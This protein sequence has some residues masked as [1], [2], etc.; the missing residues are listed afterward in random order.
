[1]SVWSERQNC[2]QCDICFMHDSSA[3]ENMAE[4]KKRMRLRGWTIGR[5]ETLC[6]VCAEK[7]KMEG[8]RDAVD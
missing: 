6:I 5:N 3:T 1:M 8:K 2:I 7:R 4:F